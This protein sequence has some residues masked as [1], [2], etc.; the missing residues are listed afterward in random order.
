MKIL[1]LQEKIKSTENQFL[2][3]LEKSQH[4]K[5]EIEMKNREFQVNFKLLGNKS[6]FKGQKCE[7]ESNFE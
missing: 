4:E 3:L 1:E 2:K 7:N 5:V 6:F